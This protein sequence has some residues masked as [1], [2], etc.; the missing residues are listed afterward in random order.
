MKR[1]EEQIYRIEGEL[2]Q[3]KG[4]IGMEER[5]RDLKAVLSGVKK[6]FVGLLSRCMSWKNRT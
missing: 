2:A 6:A 5:E 3:I 1:I 4:Q